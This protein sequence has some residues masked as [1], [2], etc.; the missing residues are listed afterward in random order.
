MEVL[1][2]AEVQNIHPVSSKAK[3]LDCGQEDE[4]LAAGTHGHLFY[5]STGG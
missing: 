5:M 4:T 1:R 2:A 3:T